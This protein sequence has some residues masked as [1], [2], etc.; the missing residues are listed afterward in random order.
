MLDSGKRIFFLARPRRFGKSLT[1]STLET[2][3]SGK[4]ELFR[5]LAVESRL[6]EELFAPRPVIYLDMSIVSSSH[7]TEMFEKTL[8]Y[9]TVVVGEKL[10]IKLPLDLPSSFLFSLLI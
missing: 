9:Y 7:G 10:G 8:R 1:A 4:K 3:L 6:D 5:G 2:L